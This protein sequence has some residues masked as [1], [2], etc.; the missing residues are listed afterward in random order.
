M[1]AKELMD[2]ITNNED[3]TLLDVRRPRE[4]AQ[5]GVI[6]GSLMIEMQTLPRE[7]QSGL[8]L[9]DKEP[10][11]VVC[12]TGN[13]SSNVVKYLIEHLGINAI[14]LEGGVV[15]WYQNGGEFENI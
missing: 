4:W 11:I 7:L 14:N 10:I 9:K 6:P 15:S 12:R 5:T 3:V 13:R 1:Q 8:N 2:K